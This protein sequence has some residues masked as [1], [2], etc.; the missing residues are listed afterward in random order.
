MNAGVLRRGAGRSSQMV[1][2][3]MKNS[4]ETLVKRNALRRHWFEIVDR[5][6]FPHTI[7][8][9]CKDCHQLKPCDWTRSFTQT[10]R[11]EYRARCR[12]CQRA[13][14]NR[15]N[16]NSRPRRSTQAMDRRYRYKKR[17][18][19]YLGG[20]CSRCGYDRCIKAM[21]FH[22]RDPVEKSFEVSARLD[23]AWADLKVELDKCDLLCF[24]CHMEEHCE[25]DQQIRV[26]LGEPRTQGCRPHGRVESERYAAA[27]S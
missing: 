27:D 6:S 1:K 25:T 2:S 20:S 13:Y 3:G 10:G 22:H 24:N 15:W 9:K 17:C 14:Q 26:D 16:R 18:A 5:S 4:P 12:D 11:P 23:Y 8:R 7:D 19:D 21:T